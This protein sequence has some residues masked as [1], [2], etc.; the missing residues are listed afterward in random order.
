MPNQVVTAIQLADR[1]EDAG[2]N[3][4]RE[5]LVKKKS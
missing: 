2:N 3:D 4:K 1:D 5:P